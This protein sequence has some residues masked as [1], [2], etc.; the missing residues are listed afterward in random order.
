MRLLSRII[1]MLGSLFMSAC[2]SLIYTDTGIYSLNDC[3][4]KSQVFL[5]AEKSFIKAY[6]L[7][8][9]NIW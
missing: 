7:F 3:L 2:S 1:G 4:A 6:G 9:Q 8:V 5:K